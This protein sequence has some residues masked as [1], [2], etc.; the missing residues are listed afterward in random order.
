MK[1]FILW[2]MGDT[3]GTVTIDAWNWLWQMPLSEI[4]SPQQ[5]DNELILDRAQQLLE[6]I[7]L[8]VAQM[9]VAAE[10][11]RISTVEI[12]R[13]YDLKYREYREII[14]LTKEY[15]RMEN[16]IEARLAMARAIVIERLLPELKQALDNSL[17]RLT[18]IQQAYTE[19]QAKLVLLEVEMQN[20]QAYL[21][22]NDSVGGN[23]Q[24]T[25][26]LNSLQARFSDLHTEIEDRYHQIQTI[27]QLSHSANCTLERTLNTQDIDD[28]IA[29]LEKN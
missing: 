8:R 15:Q 24:G 20:I 21:A 17:D 29:S 28:R 10:K 22:M 18:T 14:D 3:L 19:E 4:P 12:Q 11:V 7:S 5:I 25:D 27:A 23:P 13:Q 16:T 9:R 1:T 2:F 26:N 6:S